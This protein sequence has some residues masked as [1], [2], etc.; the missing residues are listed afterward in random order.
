MSLVQF[1]NNKSKTITCFFDFLFSRINYLFKRFEKATEE[2][3]A[4]N[5]VANRPTNG[6]TPSEDVESHKF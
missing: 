6:A 3:A 1:C 5:A 4:A 2:N